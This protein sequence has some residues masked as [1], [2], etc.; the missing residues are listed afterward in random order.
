MF[1]GNV[2]SEDTTVTDFRVLARRGTVRT[3]GW[4]TF[5]STGVESWELRASPPIGCLPRVFRSSPASRCIEVGVIRSVR[6]CP[7][8]Y[9]L[10]F[11]MGYEEL[12]MTSGWSIS[13]IPCPWLAT[14]WVIRRF[15]GVVCRV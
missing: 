4:V 10:R 3:G 5:G 11:T 7:L 9:V 8:F 13:L 14:S 15:R 6:F 1:R 12:R 2:G